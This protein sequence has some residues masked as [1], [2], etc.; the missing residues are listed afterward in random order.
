M[1]KEYA[2]EYIQFPKKHTIV[3]GSNLSLL[4][5]YCTHLCTLPYF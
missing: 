1:Q 2:S 3:S 4:N 5:G